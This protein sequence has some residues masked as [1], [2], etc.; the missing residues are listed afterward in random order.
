MQV[1]RL[2]E[3]VG[4]IR[5]MMYSTKMMITEQGLEEESE[6]TGDQVARR[7]ETEEEKCERVM[8]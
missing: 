8:T 3:Q 4:D 1:T 5:Q 7:E 6:E 2:V